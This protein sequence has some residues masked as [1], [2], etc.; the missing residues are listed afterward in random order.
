M[1]YHGNY[2]IWMFMLS[3]QY[4][5]RKEPTE[6]WKFIL[7]SI[8]NLGLVFQTDSEW[9]IFFIHLSFTLFRQQLNYAG[10]WLI[11][12]IYFTHECIVLNHHEDRAPK[13]IPKVEC[14]RFRGYFLF[15]ASTSWLLDVRKLSFWC[16]QKI[17]TKLQ[18]FITSTKG[19]H[20]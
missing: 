15:P 18:G 2:Q 14:D 4:Y 5:A 6:S 11:T 20:L 1:G 7:A 10:D 13:R 8:G 17:I 16:S 19:L 12:G 9:H 3:T